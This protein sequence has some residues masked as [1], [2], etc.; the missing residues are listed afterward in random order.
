MILNS[1]NLSVWPICTEKGNTRQVLQCVYVTETHSVATDSYRLLE[2][3]LPKVEKK[4]LPEALQKTENKIP[5]LLNAEDCKRAC[6]DL[7]ESR[8][9]LPVLDNATT[10]ASIEKDQRIASSVVL[11]IGL[12]NTRR[13]ERPATMGMYPDYAQVF[14]MGEPSTR[15]FVSA[16][17]LK[18]LCDYFSKH[19]TEAKNGDHCMMLEVYDSLHGMV[20]RGETPEGQKIRGMIMPLRMP[21][22]VIDPVRVEKEKELTNKE[23]ENK[24]PEKKKEISDSDIPF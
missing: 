24:E 23:P 22:D 14:P 1:R 12:E 8:K 18:S 11:N 16:E 6:T 17:Y 5:F 13:M 9:L 21:E 3:E 7:K 4:E 19:G 15:F 2:V 10:R 20:L